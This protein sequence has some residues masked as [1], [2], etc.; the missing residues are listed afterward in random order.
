M[1]PLPAFPRSAMPT[2]LAEALTSPHASVTLRAAESYD[3]PSL[4]VLYAQSRETELAQ[5]PW[6]PEAK[7]AFCDS[8]FDLQHRH[9]VSQ[10]SPAAAFLIVLQKQQPIGRLYLHWSADELRIV[11]ILIASTS[12]QQG[13]GS[14]LLQRLQEAV[15]KATVATLSLHVELH[16]GGAY[17]LYRRLGFSEVESRGGYLRMNWQPDHG[18]LS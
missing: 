14:A 6:P 9:Y 8:Q 11:D 18:Q 13:I 4:R 5:M 12:Q 7:R 1:E 16:N 15:S 2:W 17:R 10:Y 3:L